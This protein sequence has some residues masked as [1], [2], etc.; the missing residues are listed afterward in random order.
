V[1]GWEPRI[2]VREGLARTIEDFRQRMKVRGLL[3]G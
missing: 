2:E 3:V 1:L